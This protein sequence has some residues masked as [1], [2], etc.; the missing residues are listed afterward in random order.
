M[1]KVILGSVMA[2]AALASVSSAQAVT[3]T[4]CAGTPGNSSVTASNG[5]TSFV[6]VPFSPKCSANVHLAGDD[7]TTYYRTGAISTTGKTVFAGSTNGGGVSA[8]GTCSA[9]AASDATAAV[10]NGAS[11]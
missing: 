3:Q 8:S 10:T 5:A 6:K 2:V 4:F 7:N 11:S 9:C 1:K